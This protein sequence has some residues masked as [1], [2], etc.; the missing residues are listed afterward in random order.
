LFIFL[1][2]KAS[3]LEKKINKIELL[4]SSFSL[5]PKNTLKQFAAESLCLNFVIQIENL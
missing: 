3:Y 2:L 1:L 5:K 4:F